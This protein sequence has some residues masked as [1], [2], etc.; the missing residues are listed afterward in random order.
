MTTG[1][2][3]EFGGNKQFDLLDRETHTYGAKL[4]YFSFF[5]TCSHTYHLSR[6]E[7]PVKASEGEVE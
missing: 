7:V 3:I 6:S 4:V 1:K 2:V 5:I